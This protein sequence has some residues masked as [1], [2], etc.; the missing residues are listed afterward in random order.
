MVKSK[1]LVDLID[2]KEYPIKPGEIKS[3]GRL[4]NIKTKVP[5][6]KEEGSDKI[7]YYR[8]SRHHADLLHEKNG[9][10]YIIPRSRS[11][12]TYIQESSC[13]KRESIFKKTQIFPGYYV[14]LGDNYTFVLEERDTVSEDRMEER[15]R[16]EKTHHEEL[17][18]M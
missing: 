9:T 6:K 7:R 10:F 17:I 3:L 11:S 8:V 5:R 15:Y 18:F 16:S 2:N 14:T 13:S 1:V 4:G 12:T